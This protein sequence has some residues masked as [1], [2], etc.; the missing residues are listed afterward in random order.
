MKKGPF[1]DDLTP[2]YGSFPITCDHLPSVPAGS[3]CR[4]A[5]LQ[6]APV[7]EQLIKPAVALPDTDR[8]VERLQLPLHLLQVTCSAGGTPVGADN[9]ILPP[10]NASDGSGFNTQWRA[11]CDDL[12]TRAPRQSSLRI[13]RRNKG[14]R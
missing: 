2:I 11:I 10:S 7:G 3:V 13:T 6:L 8:G 4:R 14:G 9:S 12:V 5:H 1:F